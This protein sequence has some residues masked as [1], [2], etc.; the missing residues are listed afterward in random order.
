M[1]I[2]KKI[3]ELSNRYTKGSIGFG[4]IY[5]GTY[6]NFRAFKIQ[7]SPETVF[8]DSFDAKEY[9]LENW[10][11]DTMQSNGKANISQSIFFKENLDF[12]YLVSAKLS[13]NNKNENSGVFINC[14][15]DENNYIS[16]GLRVVNGKLTPCFCS[17]DNGIENITPIPYNISFD[18]SKEYK[19][20]IISI[21]R[22]IY[23]YLDGEVIYKTTVF[24]DY[25]SAG[26]SAENS[27]G[28]ADDF[29]IEKIYTV[30]KYEM[31]DIDGD[32]IVSS[33]DLAG[34]RQYFLSD[35]SEN[36]LFGNLNVNLDGFVNA[37]D[38]VALK[39]IL[40]GVYLQ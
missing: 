30:P 40:A 28:L 10:S 17:M 22:K 31:G 18:F 37:A 8:S 7:K 21:N 25:I 4:A 19:F 29:V 33:L 3:S 6:K 27:L 34:L 14:A 23:C 15:K 2:T 12:D 26:L 9:D 5:N 39:K 38:L 13:L 32:G 16:F 11:R 35:V 1:V 20:E 36:K 24:K